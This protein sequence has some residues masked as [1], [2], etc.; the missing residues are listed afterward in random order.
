[1]QIFDFFRIKKKIPA[2]WEK[3]YTKEELQF[4]IPDVT[5]Y[6]QIKEVSLNH[7]D[8]IAINYENVSIT[9][10]SLLKKIDICALSFKK[11]GVKKGDIIT[12]CLPNIPEVL[13]S[14]YAL[15]KLGAIGSFIHP[16]S[17]ALEI[18]E[19]IEKTKSKYLITLDSFLKKVKEIIDDTKLKKVIVVN[20]TDS[21]NIL[22][23]VGYRIKNITKM[24]INFYNSKFIRWPIFM[25]HNPLVT[26][27]IKIIGNKDT[28]AVIL[29][30]G[31]TSG[32]PKY[33]VIQNRVFI[34][35][36]IQEKIS[37][38]QLRERERV[39]A[40]MPNFH[41]FGLSVC[42]HTPLALGFTSI[43]VPQFDAKKFDVL[44]NKT[45]PTAIV[46]VP[47]LYEALINNQNIQD[48]DLSYVKYAVCGGDVLNKSLEEKINNYFLMHNANVK[49]SQGYGLTESLAAVCLARDDL[50][51]SGSTGIPF[52]TNHIKI[53]DP[54]TRKT[55]K[56]NEV[57]EIV[58]HSKGLMMGYLN[59]EVE[60]NTALQV[61]QDGH[62]WLHTGDLGYMDK[63]GFIFHKG[64]IKR[65]IIT[66]GYNVYPSHIEEIIEKHEAV[67]QCSV[68]GKPHPYKQEVVKA[69]IVLKE[70][71]QAIKEKSNIKKHCEKYLAKYMVPSEYVF[72]KQLPKTK[73]GKVDFKKLQEDSGLDDED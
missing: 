53:I 69:F 73:L 47:T 50:N 25:L 2:P 51:K 64:R 22:L 15:N 63:D 36:A 3:Y 61:H 29:N 43:L 12:I 60:T 17:T 42:M 37:L 40:V 48:L 56:T 4:S 21:L 68:V 6:E 44:L 33:V 70:G 54:A 13:I 49:V 27:D 1:M 71:H 11:L 14:F 30:S 19:S 9:Y 16:L 45:K 39:L 35:G 41:G 62:V 28:P 38:K 7:P 65:M 58:V 23:K 10:E 55:K 57:G 24:E 46:G 18:K 66:S 31:G 5:V 8:F 34:L 72:R 67:L 59:D 26:T 32:K 52:P 20:P